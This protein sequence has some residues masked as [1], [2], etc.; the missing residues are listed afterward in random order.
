MV[1]AW[2]DT[3]YELTTETELLE[4][5]QLFTEEEF[6]IKE[7]NPFLET[8]GFDLWTVFSVLFVEWFLPYVLQRD[9]RGGIIYLAQKISVR[10]YMDALQ[11][12]LDNLEKHM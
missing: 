8:A 11:L 10:D 4:G 5:D 6:L 3:R 9:A 1:S 12:I 2:F 7:L